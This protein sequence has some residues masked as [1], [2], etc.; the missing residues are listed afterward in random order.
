MKILITGGAGFIGSNLVN[1]LVQKG[2]INDIKIK[3]I[4]VI[5]NLSLGKK[6]FIQ[7]SIDIGLVDFYQYDLLDFSKTLKIFQKYDF[8]LVFHLSANSDISYGFKNTD[9]DLKQG[10]LVTYNILECIRLTG[11]KQII[12]SSSSAIYGEARITPTSED[13][14]SLLP[15]SFYGAS[16]LA[17]EGLIS[18]FCHNYK[19][20]ALIFR[21]SNIV[22]RNSTHGIL[23]DFIKKLKINP[24]KLEVLGDGKQTKP[25]LYI[26]DCIEGMLFGFAHLNDS[27]NYYNLTCDGA[28][29]VNK[30]VEMVMD[31][32]G[33][34]S[35]EIKY[36]GGKQGWSGDVSYVYLDSKKLEKLGWVAKF[37]S[38]EAI[39][40]AITDL[41]EQHI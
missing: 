24:S 38:D 3:R 5:D 34:N 11:V 40:K 20:Q 31:A 16:K 23:V 15:I 21:F 33:K 37:S 25:Y 19:I 22:G 8:D 36:A 10:I 9:W 30:I 6:E 35:T 32:M 13:Y 28:T 18:A 39:K 7:E 17:C 27:I 26:D 29:E 2:V 1:N 41:L 14:G 4:V 12:F